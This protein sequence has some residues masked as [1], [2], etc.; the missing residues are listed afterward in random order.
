MRYSYFQ[1]KKWDAD[2]ILLTND[3]GRWAFVPLA[4]FQ[5]LLACR[6]NPTDPF[7]AELLEKGFLYEGSADLYLEHHQDALR[8]AKGYLLDATSLHIFVL[9]DQCN[10]HCVYC[11]AQSEHAAQKGR[12]SRET[13]R[14]AVALA[15]QA[16]GPCLTIEFQGG[17]PLLNFDAL[18]TIVLTAEAL[19]P[20]HHKRVEFSLVS[21]LHLLNDAILAFLKDHKV[22]VSTS[23]D[24]PE[25]LHNQN[26]PLCQGGGTYAGTI[27]GL[28]RLRAA[29][30][31]AGAIETTTRFSLPRWK[32][33]V[34][35]YRA[36]DL[37]T[38]FLRP[39]TPLGFANEDWDRIGYT[40][41]EFVDFYRQALH[42]IVQLNLEGY[43]LSEGH[44]VT[45]LSKI[46]LGKGTNYMELRSPCG[47]AVGQ[48]AYYYDGN[49]YTCDEG[50]MLAEMGD[51]AFQVGTVEDSYD[52]LMNSGVC[53]ACCV[54]STL[55]SSPTCCDCV[56]QPY[57]GTCPVVNYALEGDVFSKVPHHYKC[58]TYE[59]MLDALFDLLSR[60]DPAIDRVLSSWVTMR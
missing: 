46:L 35:T 19:A 41:E 13:A 30:I 5:A 52:K 33:I 31:P 16:P 22:S 48:L 29:Q 12:M 4:A 51:R 45:F 18:Q 55:E 32:E 24:G 49:V 54:A 34:D 21:N 17:E 28:N 7:Y 53:K 43:F 57:C 44:A 14:K 47:A 40:A 42:Y 39:L 3:L 6:L 56:Y 9:T 36:L 60:H 25:D 11:Q 10:A 23:I 59:G 20:K 8:D 50:R 1:F 58:R 15:F 26:R 2:R 27:S 37:H 38:I